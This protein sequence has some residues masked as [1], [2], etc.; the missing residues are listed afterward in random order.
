MEILPVVARVP[1][2]WFLLTSLYSYSPA[3]VLAAQKAG[4]RV[5]N[6]FVHHTIGVEISDRLNIT[7]SIQPLIGRTRYLA[8]KWLQLFVGATDDGLCLQA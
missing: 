2:P 4:R 7:A 6:L 3:A 8:T 5:I 1:A